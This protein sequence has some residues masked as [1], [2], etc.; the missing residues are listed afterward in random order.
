M[1]GRVDVVAVS[2]SALHWWTTR[3]RASR[4]MALPFRDDVI[5]VRKANH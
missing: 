4:R 1:V 2:G 5:V 3:Q